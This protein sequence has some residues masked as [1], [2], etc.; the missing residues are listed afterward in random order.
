MI[1]GALLVE[2]QR[3][4]RWQEIR[5]ERAL[6]DDVLAL[7][8]QI[9]TSPT[10]LQ[11]LG[12]CLA[13]AFAVMAEGIRARIEPNLERA[14]SEARSLLTSAFGDFEAFADQV[15]ELESLSDG[16]ELVS[17][18][19]DKLAALLQGIT[20]PALRELMRK[21]HGLL[22][23]TLGLD[24]TFLRDELRRVFQRLRE[25]LLASVEDVAPSSQS[26]HF[27]LAGL[28]GRA[29]AELVP[30]WPSFDFN[31]DRLAHTAMQALERTG[32]IE[33]RDKI[34]CVLE[35]LKA[36][37]T[38][39]SGAAALA[40]PGPFA[41]GSVGAA[42]LRA[43][44]AGDTYLWYA[45]W[46][47]RKRRRTFPGITWWGEKL[48]PGMP[49]DEV[50]HSA[51]RR[52]LFLRRVWADDVM[53]H[54]A[55]TPFEW[56]DAPPFASATGEEVFSFRASA[57]CMEIYTKVLEACA[58]LAKGIVHIVFFASKKQEYGTNIPLWLWSWTNS[59]FAWVSLGANNPPLPALA[60]NRAGQP[61]FF[62]W[63]FAWVPALSVI[64][65]SIEGRYTAASA[66]SQFKY[67]VTLLASDALSAVKVSVG[68]RTVKDALLEL[69]TL[70]NNRAHGAPTPNRAKNFE[71]SDAMID[72]WGLLT[73]WILTKHVVRREDYA[74]PCAN[75]MYA[76]YMLVGAPLSGVASAMLG[77]FTGWTFAVTYDWPQF[78]FNI[79]GSSIKSLILYAIGLTQYLGMEGDTDGGKYN[80][81]FKPDG[82]DHS[83]AR[84]PFVGYP[85]P[86]TSPYKL[87]WKAGDTRFLGQGNQGLFSHMCL[88]GAQRVY[89]F[90]FALDQGEE[91][92]AARA[93]TVVDFYDFIPDDTDPDQ[94]QIDAARTESDG[95][96]G[97]GW[98]SNSP[99]ENR[100]T[101]RHD[102]VVSGH[103]RGEEGAAITTFAFYVHGRK[104][105]IREAFAARGIAPASIIG[106]TVVQGQFIMRAGDTGASFHNH[107]HMDVSNGMDVT[108]DFFTIPFV[109]RDGGELTT[110]TWYTS[111]NERVP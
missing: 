80:P 14:L 109:F 30:L 91:V 68:T 64:F 50:W 20:E 39:A 92:L 83:P 53:L 97:S 55:D 79:L 17:A 88:D 98:R 27:A 26:L 16:F 24:Q 105:S 84:K 75:G 110:L 23:D 49:P 100:I 76:L 11:S 104:G 22:A 59:T 8:E 74:Y 32:F 42:A 18:L 95:V 41:P 96:M 19:L 13:R 71:Y 107:M 6:A 61:V 69:V 35:K 72:A 103:D 58:E 56:Y 29:E 54:Q 3:L 70:I 63:L 9:A 48:F 60:A 45:T 38:A 52:Q 86:A 77:T 34:G 25:E 101:I 66:D 89:A 31:P 73:D 46:L 43:P 1:L 15:N 93:G 111:E 57:R 21:V 40:G 5:P 4:V 65:G 67:W 10:H 33:V 7:I 2:P 51:D 28:A 36:A 78:G 82:S 87:P 12:P 108:L 85:D 99:A 90:D 37:L 47:F 102:T 94:S 62:E 81:R 106:S 44:I